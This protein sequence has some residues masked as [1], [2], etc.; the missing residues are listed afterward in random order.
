M[1]PLITG[2]YSKFIA[3][4]ANDFYTALSGRLYHA[5]A[6]Q[7][8]TFPY[9]V[10]FTVSHEHDWTFEDTFEDVLIQ[11]SIFTQE[12]SAANAGIFWGYLTTLY[13]DAV[14][15]ISGYSQIYMIR[16]QSRLIRDEESNVWHYSVDYDCKVEKS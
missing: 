16:D 14:I 2:I 8:T 5:E 10:V 7:S 12:R 13:D 1:T 15:T 9:A 6:P 11:F 3:A 4:P